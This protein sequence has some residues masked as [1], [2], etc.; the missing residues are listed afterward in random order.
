MSKYV[1]I[2]KD[3]WIV[4]SE[5]DEYYPAGSL[6]DADEDMTDIVED[7]HWRLTGKFDIPSAGTHLGRARITIELLDQEDAVAKEEYFAVSIPEWGKS[8][9]ERVYPDGQVWSNSD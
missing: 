1:Y 9:P 3:L 6:F 2:A 4:M 7:A 8:V 5:S